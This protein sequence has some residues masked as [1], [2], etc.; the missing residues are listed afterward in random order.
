MDVEIKNLTKIYEMS[1]GITEQRG[2]ISQK[3][4]PAEISAGLQ[5]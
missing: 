4:S 1:R 2:Y 3:R 5:C